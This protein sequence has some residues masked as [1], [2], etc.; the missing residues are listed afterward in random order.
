MVEKKKTPAK[1]LK[2]IEKT[3]KT[4]IDLLAIEK[5]KIKLKQDEAGVVYVD[6][7]CLEP[8][9]LIGY[10]GETIINLQLIL[11]LIVYKKLG[12]WQKIIVNISD[13][14][15][16]KEESLKKLALNTAQRVKF[17]GQEIILGSL[18]SAERRIIHL[19]LADHPD[20]MT[21]SQGE[22]SERR[23]IVKP[24]GSSLRASSDAI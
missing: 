10:K 8:G 6:I 7:D 13:W 9:I 15:Q 22:G 2:L 21:E 17:S 19:V 14:R 3:V 24:R 18:N 20:V 11:A 23:L 4:L 5:P 1:Q 12:V 16:Q